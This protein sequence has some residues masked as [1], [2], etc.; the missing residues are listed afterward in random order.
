VSEP[1]PLIEQRLTAPDPAPPASLG[2]RSS[3]LDLSAILT[4]IEETAFAW[5]FPKNAIIWDRSAATVLRVANLS[6]IVTGSGFLL[7]TSADTVVDRATILAQYFTLG[8]AIDGFNYRLEFKFRPLGRTSNETL[9]VEEQG[10]WWPNALGSPTRARGVMRVIN[11]RYAAQTKARLRGEQ[12]ELTGQ[13]NRTRLM[14]HLKIATDGIAPHGVPCAFFLAS[15]NSLTVINETF[16]YEA[17]DDVLAATAQLLKQQLRD[18]DVIGR[19]ASNTFGIL[20]NNCGP[21]TM[22]VVA[23]RLMGAV[24]KT[25]IATHSTRLSATITVG[26]VSLG[27]KAITPREVYSQAMEALDEAK[28]KRSDSFVA[29]HENPTHESA[30]RRNSALANEVMSALDDDRMQLY[31]QPLVSAKTRK[32][33]H[34]ECLLRMKKLDGQLV[35]AGE[36]MPVAEQLGLSRLIDIRALHLAIDLLIAYPGV[37]LAINVSGLTSGDNEWLVELQRLTGGKRHLTERLTVEITETAAISDLDQTMVFVDTVKDLGC[38]AAI[39]DFGVGYTNFRNL[40]LLNADLLK[41]DG[42]FVRNVCQDT[43]DQVFLRSMVELANTFGMETVAEW[44]GDAATADFLTDIGITYLQ[45][46]YFAMPAPPATL[47]GPPTR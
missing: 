32:A 27:D 8:N 44:V 42:A 41:I 5:D 6:E 4:S 20:V 39:D 36:F 37:H 10:R 23:D 15:V 14:E 31:L 33:E 34:Y 9:I 24:R 35:S 19:I 7:K 26:G 2:L 46:Y 40:K 12:D 1:S 43:G 18:G 21:G 30:K 25:S 45:G 47:L 16:G 11:E 29:Y 13:L 17:G 22:Q 28:H 3:S 38:K